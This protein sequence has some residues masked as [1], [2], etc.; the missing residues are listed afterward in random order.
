[1]ENVES[2]EEAERHFFRG[3]FK[4]ALVA[5]VVGFI[6]KFVTSKKKEYSGLTVSEAKTKFEEKL[7]PRL[8]EEK[9]SDIAEAVVE[10]L[11]EKGIV[12]DDPIS[13]A[14]DEVID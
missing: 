1:M 13:D 6:A 5:A 14:V 11:K 7:G 4:L 10:K 2:V 8:G 3:L 12:I 9:A